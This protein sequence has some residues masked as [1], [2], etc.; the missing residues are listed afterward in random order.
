MY[1]TSLDG[2]LRARDPFTG[3]VIWEQ[4]FGDQF[5]YTGTLAVDSKGSPNPADGVVYG[6]FY[7]YDGGV[8]G[9]CPSNPPFYG[10]CGYVFALNAADGSILWKVGPSETGL[11]FNAR[12]AMTLSNGRVIGAA[13][14]DFSNGQVYALDAKTGQLLWLFNAT[15]LPYGGAAVGGG[16][17]YIGTTT[18]QFYA[19]DE[20]SGSVVWS[21]RLDNTITS[22]PLLNTV[23]SAPLLT[24]SMVFVG[25]YGGTMY[26]L[27]ANT[28]NTIWSTRGFSLIDVSTPATDGSALY[29]GDFNGEYVSLDRATGSVLWRTSIGAPVGSSVALANGYV[30]GTAWDGKFR[31]LNASTGKIVDTDPLL[32]FAS[33]SSPAVQRGWVWLSDYA[34]SVYGFGGV[35]A[36]EL[37]TLFVSPASVDIEVGKAALFQA[38]GLDAFDNPIRVKN[39]DWLPENG[40]GYV[41]KVSGDTALYVADIIA[42]TD[43]LQASS[44]GLTG[45]ATVHVLPGPLDRIQVYMLDPNGNRIDGPV[46][47][48]AGAHRTFAADATDRFGNPITGA[49]LTWGVTGNVGAVDATG[50]FTASTTVGTGFVTATFGGRT[51]RQAVTIVPGA[52]TTLDV[53][54]SSTTLEVDSQTLIV[55]TVR[56]AYGNANPD[57]LVSWTTGAGT[58]LPLTPDGRS[59][60]Y[61][62]PTTTTPA[63]V[64]LTATLGQVTRTITLTLVAGP[65]AEIRVA[66]LVG[67]N[68]SENP[69]S[70]PAGSQQTF[71]ADA[72]DRFGN[73]IVDATFT[74]S[75]AGTIG[76]VDATGGFTASTTPGTGFVTAAQG[77]RTGRLAVTVVPAAPATMDID[78]PSTSLSVDSQALVVATVRDAFGNANPDGV[79]R[80]TTTGTGT[81]LSLTPDGRSILY[82]AP[83]TTTPASVTLTATL[84]Q[85][86]RTITLTLVAGPPVGISINA[87]GTT[88][89]VGGVLDFSAVVTDQFGNAVT[90]ATVA[91]ETTAGT[92]NQQGVFTAPS[93]PGLVVITAS[94]AGRQSFVV[95][96]VTSG[97]LDQFSR[98]ATSA[99]SL[100]FLVAT[101]VAIAAGVFVF[102]RYREARRELEDMRKRGGGPGEP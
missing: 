40:L 84:G 60:L 62:A 32:S 95:I 10:T 30:Y 83:I 55:A 36:G 88:V 87:P 86:T 78:L 45:T 97:S 25:T 35:G 57:G 4:A 1:S 101:L 43:I 59:I 85:V 9:S 96:E 37:R 26:A 48:D 24:Q 76:T 21:V 39:A 65:T 27:D 8:I 22:A 33:T 102:V 23:A 50:A 13:W 31:S 29:F 17:V 61:H 67:G 54:L 38:H 79:V 82:H 19:L 77:G 81:V 74:W 98:Q 11:N 3:D 72:A 18:G 46:T 51:G 6:T 12:V 89:T 16:I 71:V 99:T 80:W 64:T 69:V 2:Y 58:V 92:I 49:T 42:G 47:L 68:P 73:P 44:G 91:W 70:I 15:G 20:Q 56:D 63:S 94:T 7:G 90:G 5:Y 28:G 34:G 41:V 66:M 14:N 52:P 100:G 75:V 93:Q 53:T